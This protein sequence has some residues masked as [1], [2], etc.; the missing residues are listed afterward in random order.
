MRNIMGRAISL[1]TIITAFEFNIKNIDRPEAVC[2][3]QSLRGLVLVL[4]L[5]TTIFGIAQRKQLLHGLLP[6][7]SAG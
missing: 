5:R 6:C 2:T 4:R 7:G 1:K 3:K